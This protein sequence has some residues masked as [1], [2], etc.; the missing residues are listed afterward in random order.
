MIRYV[1]YCLGPSRVLTNF[2]NI[3]SGANASGELSILYSP[4]SLN[5]IGTEPVNE[6]FLKD[7]YA[8]SLGLSVDQVSFYP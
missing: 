8:A 4:K 3:F 2:L 6:S 7:V 1:S 5:F